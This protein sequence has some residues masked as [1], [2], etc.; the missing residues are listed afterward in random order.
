M[1]PHAAPTILTVLLS[2]LSAMALASAFVG[3]FTGPAGA[4]GRPANTSGNPNR[5]KNWR[6]SA[7]SDGGRGRT[8][9]R[10][11]TMAEPR[12]SFDTLD[13]GPLVRFRPTNHTASRTASR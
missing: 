11:R 7:R 6:T 5:L 12:I 10:P 8:W 3:P 1:A 2:A 13:D 9:F 4:G